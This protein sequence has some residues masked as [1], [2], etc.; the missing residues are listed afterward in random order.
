VRKERKKEKGGG[1]G[2]KKTKRREIKKEKPTGN[3]IVIIWQSTLI[4][5]TS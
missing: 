3:K 5:C 4:K 2:N 1:R